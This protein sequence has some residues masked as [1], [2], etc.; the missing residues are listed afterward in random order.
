MVKRVF[1]GELPPSSTKS[2]A[3]SAISYGVLFAVILFVFKM[4][5]MST[6]QRRVSWSTELGQDAVCGI[7]FAVVQYF[8]ERRRGSAQGPRAYRLLID[9][10]SLSI[11]YRVEGHWS[12][13]SAVVRR[14]HV[15]SVFWVA[16]GLGVSERREFAARMLGFVVI[17]RGIPEFEEVQKLLQGWRDECRGA[18]RSRR[19]AAQAALVGSRGRDSA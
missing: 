14:A 6:A 8:L 11:S 17:P 5:L 13:P 9:E 3:A 2:R 1:M 10:D 15:R 7:L 19:S 4:L 18:G 12:V 16:G